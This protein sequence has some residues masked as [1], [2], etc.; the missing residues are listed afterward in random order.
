MWCQL[1]HTD[2]DPTPFDL[3]NWQE[4]SDGFHLKEKWIFEVKLGQG[5]A[6]CDIQL[7][8]ARWVLNRC[9]LG[10]LEG[11]AEMSCQPREETWHCGTGLATLHWHNLKLCVLYSW[12]SF[13]YFSSIYQAGI[14][15]TD[16]LGVVSWSRHMS[17]PKMFWNVFN[18]FT[19]T[20]T[21]LHEE[22]FAK[23]LNK[24]QSSSI[25][26]VEWTCLENLFRLHKL[27][28]VGVV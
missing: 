18:C 23:L 28:V 27:L 7:D 14:M 15:A 26:C 1:C 2:F 12:L 6:I 8:L 24:I 5:H 3:L 9:N 11:F 13:L 20:C 4:V 19:T 21:T 25:P 16:W 17:R 10:S 22:V